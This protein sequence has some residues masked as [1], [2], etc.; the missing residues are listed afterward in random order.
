MKYSLSSL[1]KM[2]LSTA[3]LLSLGTAV[4]AGPITIFFPT[5]LQGTTG[6]LVFQFNPNTDGLTN[7]PNDSSVS[8]TDPFGTFTLTNLGAIN[9][10]DQAITF[11]SSFTFTP[12]FTTTS[13]AGADEGNTFF[14]QVEN[15]AGTVQTT[16][17]PSGINAALTIS[18]AVDG[19]TAP[20]QVFAPFNQPAPVPEA[21]T[22]TL[23]VLLGLGSLCLLWRGRRRQ[24]S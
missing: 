15:S 16:S 8:V 12:T 10:I 19:T 2:L 20:A 3:L 13:T 7:T 23:F 18:Q 14:L 22:G 6:T 9:E 17:D 11:G 21:S 24:A 4:Q 1:P 5:A